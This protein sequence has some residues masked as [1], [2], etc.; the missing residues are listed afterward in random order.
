MPTVDQ[1]RV[2]IPQGAVMG[3]ADV[4][5]SRMVHE[6]IDALPPL[7]LCVVE[8]CRPGASASDLALAKGAIG[9]GDI[10]QFHDHALVPRCV[11]QLRVWGLPAAA[12]AAVVRHQMLPLVDLCVGTSRVQVRV[13]SSGC[14]TGSRLAGALGRVVARTMLSAVTPAQEALGFRASPGRTLL[15]AKSVDNLVVFG[16]D[17]TGVEAVLA[18]AQGWLRAHW[19]VDLADSSLEVLAPVGAA[20][21]PMRLAQAEEFK[22]LGHW[23]TSNGADTRCVR[24]TKSAVRTT[25]SRGLR[26]LRSGPRKPG[27]SKPGGSR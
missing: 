4:L 22:F 14:L 18:W 9:Q 16:R 25:T 7:P 10:R 15:A 2:L 17:A 1:V 24:S 19:S 26:V 8:G 3:I 12:C 5:L 20:V 13:R 21:A 27:G 6:V 11:E 23:I